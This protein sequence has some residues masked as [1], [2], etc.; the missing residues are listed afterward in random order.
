MKTC[1]KCMTTTRNDGLEACNICG[2]T[3]FRLGR[4]KTGYKMD[5]TEGNIIED[6]DTLTYNKIKEDKYIE[7]RKNKEVQDR[8]AERVRISRE[9]QQNTA[10]EQFDYNYSNIDTSDEITLGS[11]IVTFIIMAIPLLNIAYAIITIVQKKKSRSYINYMKAALIMSIVAIIISVAV[12]S[13]I[14][15]FIANLMYSLY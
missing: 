13:V 2:G 9:Q 3:D 12:G 5:P 11:W 7:T 14:S 4:P 15:A 10:I 8:T 1:L 6:K